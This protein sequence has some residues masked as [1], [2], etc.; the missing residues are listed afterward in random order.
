MSEPIP[1]VDPRFID[2][3][4]LTDEDRHYQGSR[5]QDVRD[6]IFANPYHNDE[7]HR[8]QPAP[9]RKARARASVRIQRLEGWEVGRQVWD[10]KLKDAFGTGETLEP[11]RAEVPQ[12]QAVDQG[13][14]D[15]GGGRLGQQHLPPWPASLMRAPR[16]TSS[17][18]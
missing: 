15:Q 13:I 8:R 2:A 11:M 9:R 4:A 5:F 12:A 17:P 6:A 18:M 7:E 14:F 10:H 16:M 3:E 1:R